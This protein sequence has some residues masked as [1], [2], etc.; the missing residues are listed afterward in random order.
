MRGQ[1]PRSERE[2]LSGKHLVKGVMRAF[3]ERLLAG[4]SKGPICFVGALGRTLDVQRV[5]LA[6][7]RR[8]PPRIWT[9]L[10]SPQALK[11]GGSDL[12]W[13]ADILWLFRL[14]V[15]PPSD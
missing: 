11:V 13:A 4:C 10:S 14:L 12:C 3:S 7:G 8:A 15:F 2:H 1:S 9:L 6:C 5:R